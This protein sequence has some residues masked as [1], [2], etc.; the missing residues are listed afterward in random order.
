[1]R[2]GSKNT[3]LTTTISLLPLIVMMLQLCP[4][5]T[6]LSIEFRHYLLWQLLF[7][8]S[9]SQHMWQGFAT[10]LVE[11]V[12]HKWWALWQDLEAQRDAVHIIVCNWLLG[13]RGL[14]QVQHGD[15]DQHGLCNKGL[16]G[17]ARQQGLEKRGSWF[18]HFYK[19]IVFHWSKVKRGQ[20]TFCF[21]LSWTIAT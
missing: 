6:R 10:L 1:M 17:T 13:Q 2:A 8:Q 3:Q 14:A 12:I 7:L 4:A 19:G 5:V 11:N 18:N 15:H 9:D 16:R 20:L 21:F